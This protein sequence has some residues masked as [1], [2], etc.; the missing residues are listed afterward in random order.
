[1]KNT[2][3]RVRPH[4]A[5]T[6]YNIVILR[7]TFESWRDEWWTS[8]REWSL[9]LRAECHHRYYLYNL[10]FRSWRTFLS[11]QREKKT[12][13][14][15]AQTF[16]DRQHMRLVWDRWKVFI[17]MRRMKKRM[18][19]SALELN[20]HVTLRSAWCLWQARLQ[21]CHEL[22]ALEGQVLKRRAL[23]LQRKAWFQWKEMHA[24]ACRQKEKESEASLHFILTQKRKALH[25]WIRYVS[26]CQNKKKSKAVAE[27][28]VYLHLVKA[29]WSK[30]SNALHQRW[31]EEERLQTSSNLSKRSIQRRALD[32]WKVYVTLCREE[33]ERNRMASQ[34]YHHHLLN[35]GLQG[36]SINI[37]WNKTN[38]LNNNM[39]VQHYHQTTLCKSWKLW[40]DSLE[41]S[42]DRSFQPLTEM[43]QKNYRTSLL[44][45]CLKYWRER[46]SQQRHL[47]EL[48]HRAEIWFTERM[49]P[50]GF[51]SWV[52]FT[53]QSRLCKQRRQKAEVYNQQRQYMWVFY[54]WW[55]Q[56]EKLRAQR[57]SEQT[58]VLHE[59]RCCT[60][61][62]W[63]RWRQRTK[64]Q[65]QAVEKEKALDHL[66][67]SRLLHKA[68]TDWKDNSTEIRER[69]NREQQACHQ[70]DLRCLKWAVE[71]WKKFVH[72]QRMKKSKLAQI[73]RYNERKLLKHTFV[74][75]KSHHSQ[76]SRIHAHANELNTRQTQ[77]FHRMVLSTWR[78]NTMLLAEDRL[79]EQQAQNHFQNVLQL[80][81]FFAWREA[82]QH[83]VS[84]RHQQEE[85]I[86]RAQRSINQVRLLWSFRQWRKQTREGQR[87][88]MCM[89]KA[90]LHHNAKILCKALKGWKT[91]HV[92]HRKNKV[93]KRQ[94]V[95]L[96]RLKM[97]QTYFEQWK[98][99]L[100]HSRREAKQTERAL[101]HWSLTLQAKVLY[102]WR[103]W[104]TD[105][106]RKQEQAAIAAQIYRD[107]LLK[108][109]VT[110]ILTYAAQMNDLTSTLTHLSQEQRSRHLQRVVKRCAMRWKQRA[111]CKSPEK[112]KDHGKAPNKS[113]TFHLTTPGLRSLSTS[114]SLEQEAEDGRLLKQ[115]PPCMPRR[116]PRRREELFGSPQTE[117]SFKNTQRTCDINS[118]ETSSKLREDS[119]SSYTSTH[120]TTITSADVV[121][122]NKCTTQSQDVLLPPSA[123]MTTATK[124][125]ASS[126]GYGHARLATSFKHHSSVH[127]AVRPRASCGE[128][129]ADATVDPASALTKE[130]MDIQLEMKNFQQDKKQLRAWQKL[131]DVLENWLQMSG[132]EE[133]MEKNE[134]LQELKQLEQRIDKLSS[135]VAKQKPAML[136]HVERIQHLQ[137][138]LQ[139]S[140]VSLLL[141]QTKEVETT[142]S[143]L[144]T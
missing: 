130:L 74:A 31:S 50:R 36:L 56:S 112:R 61:R 57:L 45:S 23:T 71:K 39:A 97:Y 59:R 144:T 123:F 15:H 48:E 33:A 40:Q 131:K 138:V 117:M 119:R 85:T 41:E 20:R 37:M 53:L 108:E 55:G 88:R 100:L 69:R 66:Y 80:K 73:Q 26:F 77:N 25:Q 124:V 12:K 42:E 44:S 122:P 22:D 4:K 96:L 11:L 95:L 87:E 18:L 49:L 60:Q 13:L 91:H 63:S 139:T 132:K 62:A 115:I 28:A 109:G 137:T 106:R 120:Q 92:Q 140:G 98:I 19:A 21:Q 113:V 111:L 5:K 1:M 103:L 82:A 10:V 102:G 121:Q 93:M 75:W 134:T 54:T 47:K 8:R 99:K 9:A 30:W 114:E 79:K 81:V 110:C 129:V 32:R 143:V 104:V 76:M 118:A 107:K 35:A 142:H 89:E 46:L 105:Q 51:N 7:R 52:E 84:R 116:Q 125:M 135:K 141:Q 29:C 94:G 3:G 72:S 133:Q 83:A 27:R 43:A 24:A 68:L 67:R 127:S 14:Q 38:R 90:R 65:I 126:S 70:G 34:H 64:Q 128:T 17:E 58:A 86:S 6:Y 136:L 2:F 78:E 101:W 16:A